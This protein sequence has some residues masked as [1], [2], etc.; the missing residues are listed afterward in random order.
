MSGASA[1]TLSPSVGAGGTP[2]QMQDKNAKYYFRRFFSISSK[3]NA[4][5]PRRMEK[6]IKHN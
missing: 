6:N 2:G 3:T 1:A 5:A 4:A